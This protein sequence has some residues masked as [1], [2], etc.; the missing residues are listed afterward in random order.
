[1]LLR[2]LYIIANETVCYPKA[3]Q[4]LDYE[5]KIWDNEIKGIKK[6]NSYAITIRDCLKNNNFYL[7]SYS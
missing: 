4:S 7:P 5:L 2:I 6:N 3:H 1:M